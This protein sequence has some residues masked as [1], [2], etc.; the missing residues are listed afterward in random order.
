MV[1]IVVSWPLLLLKFS[2]CPRFAFALRFSAGFSQ[3]WG[4]CGVIASDE[5]FDA[6]PQHHPASAEFPAHE[7]TVAKKPEN[8]FVGDTA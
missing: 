8:S 1:R 7:F 5:R 3:L 6:R 2:C 4:K